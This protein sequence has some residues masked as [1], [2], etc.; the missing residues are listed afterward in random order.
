MASSF[1]NFSPVPFLLGWLKNSFGFFCY[2]SQKQKALIEWPTQHTAGLRSKLLLQHLHTVPWLPGTPRKVFCALPLLPG[3]QGDPHPGNGVW[4]QGLSPQ[5]K[6]G[7]SLL[8][9]PILLGRKTPFSFNLFPE[10]A[11]KR[12]SLKIRECIRAESEGTQLPQG[13]RGRVLA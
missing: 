11:P 12:F 5:L 7:L 1:N 13:K 3:N 2:I 8:L 9:D 4:S 10:L 6:S